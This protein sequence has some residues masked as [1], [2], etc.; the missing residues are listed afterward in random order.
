MFLDFLYLYCLLILLC[1]RVRAAIAVDAPRPDADGAVCPNSERPPFARSL[2]GDGRAFK[3]K[4]HGEACTADWYESFRGRF[5]KWDALEYY[6]VSDTWRRGD[7]SLNDRFNGNLRAALASIRAK[8]WILPGTTDQV[9]KLSVTRDTFH[10]CAWVFSLTSLP[11]RCILSHVHAAR[12][13]FSQGG[14]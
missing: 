7:C 14:D 1:P 4:M 2:H 10:V 5:R 13:V 9:R 3:D 11:A 6:E 8:M 12:I